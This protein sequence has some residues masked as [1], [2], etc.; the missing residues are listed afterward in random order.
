MAQSSEPV[1]T[2]PNGKIRGVERSGHSAVLGIPFA[3]APVVEHLP[4]SWD[5]LDRDD[6][7]PLAVTLRSDHR[8]PDA[9][10]DT[11]TETTQEHTT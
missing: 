4:F 1:I 6:V 10:D 7:T 3:E 8:P 2:T 5:V 9:S 11:G